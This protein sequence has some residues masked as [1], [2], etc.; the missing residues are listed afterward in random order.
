MARPWTWKFSEYVDRTSY[1]CNG[2]F[3]SCSKDCTGT[4]TVESVVI[5][6]LMFLEVVASFLYVSCSFIQPVCWIDDETCWSMHTSFVRWAA[7]H[8][9]MFV[10]FMVTSLI[11]ELV[12][13]ILFKWCHKDPMPDHVCIHPPPQMQKKSTWSVSYVCVDVPWEGFLLCRLP[14]H[15]NGRSDISPLSWPARV[16]W[17]TFLFATDFSV[18]LVVSESIVLLQV[19]LYFVLN[20]SSVCQGNGSFRVSIA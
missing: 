15:T 10:V 4:T 12:T 20:Y 16:V 13:I 3:S 5:S 19:V 9:K 1:I 17:S 8:E 18:S 11:Y 7:L 6:A 14:G 2:Q